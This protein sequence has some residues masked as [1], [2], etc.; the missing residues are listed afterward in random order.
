MLLGMDAPRSRTAK[1]QQPRLMEPAI[2]RD[3]RPTPQWLFD[4]LNNEF[5]F[6]LDAAA[7]YENAKC[8]AFYSPNENGLAQPW[9]GVVWC[10]PPYG[11]EMGVWVGKGYQSAEDGATVVML[12]PASTDTHWF[13]DYC[14]K[15]EV[16]FIRGRIKFQG[17]KHSA[18]FGSMVVVFRP[19]KT[20][21]ARGDAA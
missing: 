17:Q 20:R 5:Q 21:E 15:A 6:T 14:L 12:L 9:T 8:E 18:P 4:A 10:N 19:T 1:R 11:Q 16:R 3:D 7:S 13:H 2:E